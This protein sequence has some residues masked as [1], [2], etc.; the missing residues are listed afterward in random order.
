MKLLSAFVAAVVLFTFAGVVQAQA[1]TQPS[2]NSVQGTISKVDA[3][4]KKL[5]VDT[6][7]EE[8]NVK[9]V[10]VEV[11][12]NAQIIVDGEAG[13]FGDLVVGMSVQTQA[14]QDP[15]PQ[16]IIATSPEE[17]GEEVAE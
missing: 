1:Q 3:E 16:V 4:A 14:G 17:D 5:T 2:E 9:Q 7:D 11:G 6:E 12:D 13:E 15:A 10:M 8:G